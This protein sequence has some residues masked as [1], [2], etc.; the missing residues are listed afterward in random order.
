MAVSRKLLT[1]GEEVVL[2][3][4]THVK[5]LFWPVLILLLTCFAAGF[6]LVVAPDGDS[7]KYLTYVI[8][9]AAVLVLIVW[10]LSP[11]IR[12]LTSTY[13]VTN[14]RLIFQTGIFTRSGRVIPLHRI[15]DV[16]FEKHLS[17]RMFGCGTLIIH[18][19]SEQSGLH[20]PDIPK[21]ETVHRTITDLVF[22]L[23]DGADDDGTPERRGPV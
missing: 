2:S 19:A 3:V 9:A 17:D 20:L 22:G 10:V 18:D 21:V 4:R 8:L 6:L 23:H 5:A 16:S 14:R 12:W 13:T 15:N 11:F 7:G 1:E